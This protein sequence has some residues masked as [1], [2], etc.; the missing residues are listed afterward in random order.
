MRADDG[1]LTTLIALVG[2][3]DALHPAQADAL[4]VVSQNLLKRLRAAAPRTRFGVLTLARTQD[5]RVVASAF[6]K[7]GCP[8]W[9]PVGAAA[10]G[11]SENVLPGAFCALDSGDPDA[12]VEALCRYSHLLIE[13][14][15]PDARSVSFRARVVEAWSRNTF[16]F[17]DDRTD[18]EQLIFLEPP[19]HGELISL[20]LPPSQG[21][22]SKPKRRDLVAENS[23]RSVGRALAEFDHFNG[24]LRAA[25]TAVVR[26]RM[27][28]LWKKGK[29]GQSQVQSNNDPVFKAGLAIFGQG[30]AQARAAKRGVDAFN[31]AYALG[32]VAGVLLYE[33]ARTNIRDGDVALWLYLAAFG[34]LILFA[35]VLTARRIH[36][37]MLNARGVAELLRAQLFWRLC[38]VD[39]RL[40]TSIRRWAPGVSHV[41][42]ASARALD[43]MPA[44]FGPPQT[45]DPAFFADAFVSTQIKYHDEYSTKHARRAELLERLQFFAIVSAFG[46]ALALIVVAGLAAFDRPVTLEA[47]AISALPTTAGA[48]AIIRERFSYRVLAENYARMHRLAKS[49]LNKLKETPQ[50]AKAISEQFGRETIK[51]S[52]EWLQVHRQ[53]RANI[54]SLFGG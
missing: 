3:A 28:N 48:I 53:R 35:M 22:V 42:E 52:T 43:F 39:A 34:L 27:E 14:V 54:Q 47:M 17:G 33:F 50:R 46:L 1:G 51:E 29:F 8:V 7:M 38:G 2:E 32:P 26:E 9:I 15:P 6:G 19:P 30:S 23:V 5:E 25:D 13:I 24:A 45:T 16:H 41:L 11:V 49:A 31:Y 18:D 37:R 44:S 4:I 10:L 36:T 21:F 40:E 12:A 20:G